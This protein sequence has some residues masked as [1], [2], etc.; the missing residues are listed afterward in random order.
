M[1]GSHESPNLISLETANAKAAHIA[2]VIFGGGTAQIAEKVEH[3]MFSSA[4]H[5]ARGIDGYA[6]D[7][8]R[9]DLSPL[10]C[11]QPIHDEIMLIY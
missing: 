3:C 4:G 2:V 6:F 5:S 1:L 11:V 10:F 9:K 8:S 7:Q